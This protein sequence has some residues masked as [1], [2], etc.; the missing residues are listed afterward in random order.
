[1]ASDGG[2]GGSTLSLAREN[3]RPL[4]VRNA[5]KLFD[6]FFPRLILFACFAF[7]INV[8]HQMQ[9]PKKRFQTKNIDG[10]LVTQMLLRALPTSILLFPTIFSLSTNLSVYYSRRTAKNFLREFYA[11]QFSLN[12]QYCS[13]SCV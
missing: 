5:R 11:K 6:G 4:Y 12:G 9:K 1:M 13:P 10:K 2:G 3:V 7:V 8:W